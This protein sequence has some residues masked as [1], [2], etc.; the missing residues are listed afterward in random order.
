[1]SI[2]YAER[3]QKRKA[4]TTRIPDR[5]RETCHHDFDHTNQDG[6]LSQSKRKQK[7]QFNEVNNINTLVGLSETDFEYLYCK[8]AFTWPGDELR[9]V[10]FEAYMTVVHPNMPVL[11][12][13][14]II[15][16]FS[17]NDGP[18]ESFSLFL[19]QAMMAAASTAV[20][21]EK[22]EVLGFSSRQ[23]LTEHFFQKARG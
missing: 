9:Q 4:T 10:L 6:E 1:M 5:E 7:Q 2:L 22:I 23:S 18:G 13:Q 15:E 20:M 21:V 12:I 16:I 8:G 19:G 3:P 14:Q 17:S 11:R